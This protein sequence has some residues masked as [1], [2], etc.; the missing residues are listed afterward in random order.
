MINMLLETLQ[1]TMKVMVSDSV[2]LEESMHSVVT[3]VQDANDNV[4]N[5]SATMQE[6][7]A[8]M[9]EVAATIE[10]VNQDAGEAGKDVAQILDHTE[11]G[12][13]FA[14]TMKEKAEMLKTQ[15]VENK[16]N[17]D[18]MMTDMSVV[19][20]ESMENSKQVEQ[21][22]ELTSDILDISSQTNLL[23]LNASIEAARAGE[24]GKGFAVVADEIRVLADNSR[25]TANNIQ[26]ISEIVEKSVGDLVEN[27]GKILEFIHNNILK[28]YDEMV[29]MGNQYNGDAGRIEDMMHLFSESTEK[30][31]EVM[32]NIVESFQNISVTVDE[33]A[34]GVMSVS[35][36]AGSLVNSMEEICNVVDNNGKIENELRNAVSGCKTF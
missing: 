19:L 25:E 17:T 34:K 4:S 21:I 35:D 10:N 22:H 11:G 24:A 15:A 33:S 9:Q 27:S 26:N 14:H 13:T 7:A 8:S 2:A 5:T 28:D 30:L 20:K 1:S 36:T 18:H 29:D 6:L 12:V 16:K 31:Q 23:A 32:Q 3:Q